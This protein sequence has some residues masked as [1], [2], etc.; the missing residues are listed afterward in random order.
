M[1][2]SI[3]SS[4]PF[5]TATDTTVRVFGLLLCVCGHCLCVHVLCYV[6][7]CV[8][9]GLRICWPEPHISA[10]FLFICLLLL[11]LFC[12]MSSVSYRPSK[13][14]SSLLCGSHVR[15]QSH[16]KLFLCVGHG[17]CICVRVC[18]CHV[19]CRNKQIISR[20]V[21]GY[22]AG[23]RAIQT[24]TYSS[25]FLKHPRKPWF[26]KQHL[27]FKLWPFV[28]TT[29]L[30]C[31]YMCALFTKRYLYMHSIMIIFIYSHVQFHNQT[32]GSRTS[33]YHTAVYQVQLVPDTCVY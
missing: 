15:Q 3:A 27:S 19:S 1:A 22:Y 30:L 13:L 21:H 14:S 9:A 23:G 29:V 31:S 18:A 28:T 11:L 26:Q 24:D 20:E 33:S 17:R 25:E 6:R 4:F 16:I 12:I 8:C 7:V 32:H 2:L 10:S 5:L